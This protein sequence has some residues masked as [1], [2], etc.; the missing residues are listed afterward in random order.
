MNQVESEQNPNYL[1]LHRRTEK[2]LTNQLE[3]LLV[4]VSI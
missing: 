4:P 2:I 1:Y 3:P